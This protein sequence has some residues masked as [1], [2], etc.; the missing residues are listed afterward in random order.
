EVFLFIF[1]VHDAVA[2]C[3]AGFAAATDAAEFEVV[4]EFGDGRVL[5]ADGAVGVARDF[6][7][8]ESH[9]HRVE[10]Q[11][12]AHARFAFADDEFDGF[13]G[14]DVADDAADDAKHAAFGA[15]RDEPGR[16]RFGIPAPV[17]RPAA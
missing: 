15:T 17:T 3:A 10:A 6:V 7:F 11:Q 1:L 14:L 8:A 5:A 4:D 2:G 13:V 12:P 16:R 9:V